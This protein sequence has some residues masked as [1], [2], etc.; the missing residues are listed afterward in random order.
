MGN[1]IAPAI[2]GSAMNQ[3]YANN[4]QA[5]LP[6]D[7]SRS[8]DEAALASLADPRV[9]LS[10]PAMTALKKS[11]NSIGERGPALFEE[12]VKAIRSAFEASL[13]MVFLIAAITTLASWLLILTIPEVPID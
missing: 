10:E 1:A 11:C 5:S 9:L 12:T 8:V 7:L 4:L 2:L 3:S 6:A 13:K